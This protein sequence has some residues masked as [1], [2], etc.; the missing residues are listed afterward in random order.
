MNQ[1]QA[2]KIIPA[3]W[4][5]IEKQNNSTSDY[6][7][8]AIDWKR[9]ARWSWE[10]WNDLADLLQFNI[11]VRRKLGSPNYSSQPCAKIAKKAIVL[12]MNEQ[13]YD[14]FETL[15]YKPFSKKKWNSFLKEYRQ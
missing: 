12:R 14:G 9:K 15:L 8:Y 13:Q 10:G 4:I 7:L 2:Q 3:T 6:I 11:P 1:R 5:M